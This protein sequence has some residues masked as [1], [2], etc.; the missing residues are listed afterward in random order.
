MPRMM[1][2][3]PLARAAMVGGTAYV[4]SRA[5]AKAG[6]RSAGEEQYAQEQQYAP[7]PQYAPAEPEPSTEDKVAQIQQLKGLLDA[8]AL[9]QAEFDF[10]KTKIL[11]T[12]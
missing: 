10:Q 9:T 3:R 6:A 2:R 8:G 12:M 7:E 11:S 5:G 4:A 1:R